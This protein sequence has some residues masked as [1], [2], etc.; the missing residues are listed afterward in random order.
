MKRMNMLLIAGAAVIT[1]IGLVALAGLGAMA[2]VMFDLMSGTATGSETLTP[3]GSPAG[4]ALVVYNPGLTGG[5]K[6]V[7]AAIAGDLKDA[8]Y[9]VV[10]AGV[11][12]RAAA[13]VAGYDVIVVGGPVYAGNA[14]GSIRSY[15]GQLD[16]AEG[17]K[18]GAFGCGSKEID[19]A[20]RTAVLADVAGDTTL[21]IRAALKLT[22][23]D[24]RDEECAAFVDRLLG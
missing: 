13:D 22:Q 17:A 7:A 14:S 5:A 15:L 21:D 8:G 24:D 23:W 12:S 20:D 1:A 2:V 11:K 19:N 3:A 16:P 18:V 4:H 9:S 6:T 10:L